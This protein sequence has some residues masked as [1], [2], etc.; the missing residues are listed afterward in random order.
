MV[1]ERE[2]DVLLIRTTPNCSWR[3]MSSKQRMERVYSTMPGVLRLCG[4]NATFR[5]PLQSVHR[6]GVHCEAVVAT[7]I[8]CPRERACM[9]HTAA[10]R[11]A[12]PCNVCALVHVLTGDAHHARY[13]ACATRQHSTLGQQPCMLSMLY[14][15][16]QALHGGRQAFHRRC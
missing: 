5:G 2:K 12:M 1:P 8:L 6:Q 9:S 10:L 7:T 14:D 15:S 3:W 4:G 13:D 16:L 11:D